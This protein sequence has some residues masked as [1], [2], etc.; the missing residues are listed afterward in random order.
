MFPCIKI[1]QL[2]L[3]RSFG[4]LFILDP[5]VQQQALQL[6]Y[7]EPLL[8]ISQDSTYLIQCMAHHLMHADNLSTD[9]RLL[10]AFTAYRSRTV[11][12]ANEIGPMLYRTI[13]RLN[14]AWD[15]VQLSGST[16]L[17]LP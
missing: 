5:L 1:D 15:T 4:G 13:D 16:V 10:L 7:L 6:R 12:A 3:P 2:C 8:R 9:P 17:S 14:L 11:L